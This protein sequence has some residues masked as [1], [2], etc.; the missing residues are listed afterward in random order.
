MFS[1]A[2]DDRGPDD[3]T[4]DYDDYLLGYDQVRGDDTITTTI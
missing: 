1:D 3:E 4:R 2:D